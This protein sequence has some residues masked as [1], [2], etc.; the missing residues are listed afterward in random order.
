[1]TH[2][3]AV[4]ERDVHCCHSVPD[5]SIDRNPGSSQGSKCDKLSPSKQDMSEEPLKAS[6]S[7]SVKCVKGVIFLFVLLMEVWEPRLV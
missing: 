4:K 2:G 5:R 7:F 1:M 3:V 6:P